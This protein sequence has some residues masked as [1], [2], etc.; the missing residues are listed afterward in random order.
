MNWEVD[1]INK[2]EKFR[3][4]KGSIEKKMF[5]FGQVCQLPPVQLGQAGR[6]REVT[7][8][9]AVQGARVLRPGLPG[10]ALEAHT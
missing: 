8:V 7:A 6:G 3:L 1:V 4:G 9:Q 2:L 5:S 10:G